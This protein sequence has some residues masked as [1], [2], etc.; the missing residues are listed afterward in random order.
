MAENI[1]LKTRVSK[2]EMSDPITEAADLATAVWTALPLTLRDDEI[3]ISDADPE[4]TEVFS[5]END[6][7]EDYDIVGKGT[8]ITGSFINA[9][10]AQL[11]SLMG[12][13]SVGAD[14]AM[15]VHRSATKV[16]L[17]KALKFTLTNGGDIIV[18]NAKGYVNLSAGVGYSG[19]TKYPFK[20]KCLVA[21]PAWDVDIIL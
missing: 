12:G 7:A 10:R 11:V 20:F 16:S 6:A 19:K 8:N 21:A 17:N 13:T 15:R 2:I 9:T 3:L 5:H 1:Y 14:A 18:P 4:E